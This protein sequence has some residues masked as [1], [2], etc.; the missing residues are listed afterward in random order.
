MNRRRVLA[1][2][3]AAAT[4]GVAGC[5]D[6]GTG[7]NGAADGSSGADGGSDGGGGA[8]ADGAFPD[9][10]WRDGDG[11]EVETLAA[12]HVAST[13]DA[14][15]VTLLSTA[16]T[17]HDGDAE[18]TPWLRSQEYE[19][20]YDLGNERQYLR[21]E[22]TDTDE[23][24]VSELYVADGE[25][26]I[27]RRIGATVRYDRRTV[28]RSTAEFE[29]GMRREATT[30]IRPPDPDG[31]DEAESVSH[32]LESWDPTIDGRGTADG[33]PTARFVSDAF[34]GDR[35]IPETTETAAATVDVVESGFVPLIAQSWD[36]PHDGTTA[37]VAVDIEYRD[38]G[39]RVAEP[40]WATDARA[41]A[42]GG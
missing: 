17:T 24:D 13:V 18:P 10:D 33:E 16:V 36:G 41:A 38:R 11:L 6:D 14:G 5:N 12:R 7:G 25:A 32:G 15:G 19:S 1:T 40:D 39:A 2:L 9:A 3:G 30:G 28:D 20:S 31:E 42:N 37:S 21:Q 35:P 27:R 4:V 34:A 23:P 29:T 26:L 22:L 8:E